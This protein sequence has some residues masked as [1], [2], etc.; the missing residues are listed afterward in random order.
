MKR[1]SR[2]SGSILDRAWRRCISKALS[3]VPRAGTQVTRA[4]SW[5]EYASRFPF[6]GA[7][8]I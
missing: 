4:V 3:M 6:S 2:T 1:S 7:Q 8:E 5:T